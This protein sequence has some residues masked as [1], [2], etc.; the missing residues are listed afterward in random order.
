MTRT[1]TRIGAI[2]AAAALAATVFP[3][4][5]FAAPRDMAAMQA[6]RHL[7]VRAT[8]V[9]AG[10]AT[11]PSDLN[12]STDD[13]WT[14]AF[15]IAATLGMP[16]FTGS[17]EATA[18]AFYKADTTSGGGD[19]D[20]W[21]F[22][23]DSS[24]VASGTAY[25][26]EAQTS[27][28][29]VD[30]IIDV[31][32]ADAG[33]AIYPTPAD[34]LVWPTT[35]VSLGTPGAVASNDFGAWLA[36]GL[37]ASCSYTPTQPGVYYVRVRPS[38]GPGD[39]F[40]FGAGPYQFRAKK[41]QLSRLG[42]ATRLDVALNVS[43]EQFPT[44]YGPDFAEGQ[45]T[46]VMASGF[47]FSDALPAAALAYAVEGPLLMLPKGVTVPAN[48]IAEIRRYGASRV[49]IVGGTGT[50][51]AAQEAALKKVPGVTT[52][53]R[54]P[55]ADRFAV[56]RNIA[57]K[58]EAEY[59]LAPFAFVVNGKKFPD[60][61]SATPMSG[62][63]VAPILYS[64]GATVD[65]D[66]LNTISSLGITDVCIVGGTG[67]VSTAAE[68]Q[69]KARLGATHVMRIGGVDRFEA[70]KNF[71]RWACEL[72]ELPAGRDG[73]VGTPGSP[74]SLARLNSSRMGVASGSVFADALAGG[75]FAGFIGA[76]VILTNGN[77]VSR[78]IHD[79]NGTLPA[80][81]TDWV[82]DVRG[83]GE[84][85]RAIL[86]SY[87]FGGPGTVS[88]AVLRDLDRITGPGVEK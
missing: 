9:P 18:R 46:V 68:N 15:D 42:G 87:V 32:R 25:L 49:I 59:G 23:V 72:T 48:V 3:E 61:L 67:S 86:R 56:A 28:T 63:N 2:V 47:V 81:K 62:Y 8:A 36:F 53:Q 78:W 37:G 26:F 16:A 80:G 4:A 21:T 71:A 30:P 50:V 55:G 14:A 20:W 84:G 24:D 54:V 40:N 83:A 12:D 41:G 7:G 57:V 69:L 33:G 6:A 11:Y 65:P 85:P 51:T 76:P 17:Y 31:Y 74:S 35:D 5:V 60:A 22:T 10:L 45:P 75:S 19:E 38:F 1:M 58:A 88:D 82:E 77:A 64:N 29:T 66:T 39:G 73:L 70:S 27:S 79:T 34:Q 52:V 44:D 43:R 13:T